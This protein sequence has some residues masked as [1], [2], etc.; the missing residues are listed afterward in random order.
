[1]MIHSAAY[2]FPR[3]SLLERLLEKWF[4]LSVGQHEVQAFGERALFWA[5]YGGADFGECKS[6]VERIGD[7]SI[8]DWHREWV[9]TA[10]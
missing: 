7:C 3:R 5:P 1:M 2:G 4:E 8:D 6:T 10:D 9:A